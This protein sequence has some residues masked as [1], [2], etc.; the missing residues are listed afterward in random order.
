MLKGSLSSITD[1]AEGVMAVYYQVVL[2]LIDIETGEKVWMG[3]KKIKK[4]IERPDW[5]M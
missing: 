4:V 5:A 2:T 3:S 1:R